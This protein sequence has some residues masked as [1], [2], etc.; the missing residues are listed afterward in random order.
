MAQQ[1]TKWQSENGT[2]HD[3]QQRA[4]AYDAV[5]SFSEFCRSAHGFDLGYL[6]LYIPKWLD[7]LPPANTP[8]LDE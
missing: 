5:V 7:T 8:T 4:D 6:N 3:T 1:V 2:L